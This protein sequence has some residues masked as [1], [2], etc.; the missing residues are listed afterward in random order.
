M[1][2]IDEM[3]TNAIATRK[4]DDGD[5]KKLAHAFEQIMATDAGKLVLSQIINA[6]GVFSRSSGISAEAFVATRAVGIYIMESLEQAN[7][8]LYA[9]LVAFM[10]KQKQE[11]IKR[12]KNNGK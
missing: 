9:E 2:T 6:C 5:A 1:S 3:L 12:A 8:D 11:K 7:A 10:L 4:E